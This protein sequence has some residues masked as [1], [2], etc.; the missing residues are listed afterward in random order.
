MGAHIK[1]GLSNL[2]AVLLC[3]LSVLFAPP[4]QFV[5]E[6]TI[7]HRLEPLMLPT[8]FLGVVLALLGLFLVL[9]SARAAA[10]C[11]IGASIASMVG[12]TIGWGDNG[13]SGAPGVSFLVIPLAVLTITVIGAIAAL[14]QVRKEAVPTSAKEPRFGA[15]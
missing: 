2:V 5:Q 6:P 15:D 8:L 11:C 12:Q 4:S 7:W 10:M 13:A 1:A 3:A 9:F 14:R